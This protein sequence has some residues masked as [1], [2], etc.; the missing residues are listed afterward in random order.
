VVEP[1]PNR[2]PRR[3]RTNAL[4]PTNR[5]VIWAQSGGRCAY[6]GC[7]RLLIG[8]LAAG[9]VDKHFGFI[10]HIVADTPGGPRGDQQRSVELSNDVRNL[11]LLCATHHKLIDET[12]V[13]EHPEDRLLEMKSAH[14]RRVAMLTGMGPGRASHVLRYAA[15]IGGH[16]S[17]IPFDV[18]AATMLPE[19]FPA[20]GRATIDI[21]IGGS[22]FH[23]AERGDRASLGF[24]ARASA[25]PN[26]ARASSVRYRRCRRPPAAS[27]A[28]GLALGR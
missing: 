10:A 14:E 20:E 15:N 16:K 2:T 22:A 4:S 7:N 23:D 13:A 26:R 25:A 18:V 12:A 17:P 28:E 19:R 21:G 3:A 6:P 1:T 9:V 11:M 27:R 5:I 24:R 8:D